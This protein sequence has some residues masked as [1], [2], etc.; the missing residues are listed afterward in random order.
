MATLLDT[1]HTSINESL[2]RRDTV[3]VET[4]RFLF[5]TIQNSAIAKYGA[6]AK[7]S[8]TDADCLD[9][10]KKQVKTHKESITAYKAGNRE[11]LVAR[12]TAELVILEEYLPQQMSDEELKT[13]LT[14]VTSS[15]EPNFGLL[16]KQAMQLVGDRAD[17]Q[18]VSSMLKALRTP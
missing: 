9:A 15:Q 14:P 4:L 6:Q 17:G 10:I 7:T 2:K 11:D 3:R 18:R 8:I 5:A 16:M 13:L 1:I 12:E